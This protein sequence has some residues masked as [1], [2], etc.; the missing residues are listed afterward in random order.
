VA[1]KEAIGLNELAEYFR[2]NNTLVLV[3]AMSRK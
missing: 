2:R 3:V 1:L